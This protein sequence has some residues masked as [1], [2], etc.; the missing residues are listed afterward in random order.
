L[1]ASINKVSNFALYCTPSSEKPEAFILT[2]TFEG[3]SLINILSEGKF[4]KQALK[5]TSA[6]YSLLNTV[7][8]QNIEENK[9][10]IMKTDNLL[11]NRLGENLE[12]S[13]LL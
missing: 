10:Q 8:N 4:K 3:R 5:D 6:V 7:S 9:R 2:A 1:E 11:S 13:E 12:S